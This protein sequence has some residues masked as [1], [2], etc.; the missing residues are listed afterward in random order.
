MIN[1]FFI[2][3]LSMNHNNNYNSNQKS[4]MQMYS[5][6]PIDYIKYYAKMGSLISSTEANINNTDSN[7]TAQL[8]VLV[9]LPAIMDRESLE[10]ENPASVNDA[11]TSENTSNNQQEICRIDFRPYLGPTIDEPLLNSVECLLTCLQILKDKLA[12]IMAKYN[13]SE[14]SRN[15]QEDVNNKNCCTNCSCS[16]NANAQVAFKNN[17][18]D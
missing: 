3:F 8:P 15:N 7:E 5:V 18:N 2:R 12:R 11:E 9:S 1:L 14:R 13:R 6:N 17:K 4:S 16:R 10:Y